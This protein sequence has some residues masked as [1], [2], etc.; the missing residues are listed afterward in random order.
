[1][2]EIVK[3]E[4]LM[5]SPLLLET[6]AARLAGC[7]R[8]YRSAFLSSLLFGFLAYGFAFT[9]KLINHDEAHCLFA[10]GATVASG[11]WGLGALD[12]I[13]PNYSMPWIYGI[14]TVFLIACAVCLLVSMFRIRNRLLQALLGGAVT[15]FPSLIGL[16]GYMFTSSSFGLSFFLAVLSV[17]LLQKR[18]LWYFL[19]AGASLVFSLSIYQS[20]ISVAAA[21]LVLVL[22]RKLLTGSKAAEV[23]KLGIFYVAFLVAALLVYWVGT[24]AVL[25]LTGTEMGEY[26]SGNFTFSPSGILRGAFIAYRNFAYTFLYPFQGLVPTDFS[27][28]LH[29]V[30]LALCPVLLVLLCRHKKPDL[31]QLLLLGALVA[32]FPLA[33][34]CMYMITSEDSIHTL[35]LYSFAV[36]YVFILVLADLCLEAELRKPVSKAVLN[37]VTLCLS[38]VIV[39]N[40]YVANQA[41]LHLHLRYENAYAFYTS[42]AADIKLQPEFNE[43][44]RL[45]VVGG[46]RQPDFYTEQFTHIHLITGAYGFVPDSY[47]AEDFLTCYVGFPV[48]FATEAETEAIRQSPEFA[49]MPVYPY[50]GSLRSFGDILVV[51]LS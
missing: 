20:Y 12:T 14:L 5:N 26:A 39:I 3:G 46:Y 48:P 9:N 34:N 2:K 29:A 13:F 22:I 23:L 18:T 27:R 50:Y 21:L 15:V 25:M 4:S 24:Q 49:L 33:I 6:A 42:L 1:M 32:V 36:F 41:Y 17:W 16:F 51:K 40:T 28:L 38:L 19:A 30:L 31:C 7:F 10:K 8:Q 45:A 43:E 44:T 47:S 11:R 35:V 37:G